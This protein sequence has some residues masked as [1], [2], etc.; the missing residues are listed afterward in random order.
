MSSQ[1]PTFDL[2][3]LDLIPLGALVLDKDMKVIFWNRYLEHITKIPKESMEGAKIME[4][5]PHLNSPKYINRIENI[6]SGGPPVLFSSLLHKYII[7]AQ[8]KNGEYRIQQT[9]VTAIP[10]EGGGYN[11]L[12]IIE[13][14]T[15][16][17]K[18]IKEYRNMRDKALSEIEERIRIEAELRESKKS[19]EKL[20]DKLKLLSSL[21]GLT[22][23][24]NRR[25]F[26]EV[27]EREWRRGARDNTPVALILIDLDFFKL[28]NDNYGHLAGDECLKNIARALSNN[29]NRPGDFVARYGGEEFAVIL[30]STDLEGA[31]TIARQLAEGIKRMEIIHAYSKASDFVTA[32]LGVASTIPK[33]GTFPDLLFKATDDALYEAKRQGR[34]RIVTKEVDEGS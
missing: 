30:P 28:Y 29:L 31:E 26:D 15:S 16:L 14:V 23:I 4:R 1:Q 3:V 6:F 25:Y 21:D 2:G 20:A 27:F 18:R 13:D 22:E 10:A 24:A 33:Q 34:D 9:T 32:S 5:F 17:T 11:A 8:Q 7:P 19:A 12:F